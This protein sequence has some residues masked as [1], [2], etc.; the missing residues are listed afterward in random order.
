MYVLKQKQW[1]R[2]L[3]LFHYEVLTEQFLMTCQHFSEN[4]LVV[5]KQSNNSA[6]YRM[7]IRVNKTHCWK[8]MKNHVYEKQKFLSTFQLETMTILLP[9]VCIQ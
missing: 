2:Q 8:P 6:H 9:K 5:S 3:R 7:A 1:L 4:A